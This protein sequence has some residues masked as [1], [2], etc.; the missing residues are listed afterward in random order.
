[1]INKKDIIP[2]LRKRFPDFI[3]TPALSEDELVYPILGD[4]A[5]YIIQKFKEGKE[6]ELNDIFKFI[7]I[8]QTDADDYTKEAA[9]IGVLESLQNKNIEMQRYLG[10]VSL[11]QWNKLNDF[12]NKK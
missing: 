11:E 12:W 4:F 8:L 3:I 7:E 1:M 5:R 6:K 2:E 9:T 10:K